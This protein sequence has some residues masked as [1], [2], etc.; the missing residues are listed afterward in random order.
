MWC[1]VFSV[2]LLSWCSGPAAAEETVLSVRRAETKARP[3][4]VHRYTAPAAKRPANLYNNHIANLGKE[5]SF[6]QRESRSRS[7]Y[8]AY[9]PS[10]VLT[11]EDSGASHV[12][13]SSPHRQPTH[14]AVRSAGLS[15]KEFKLLDQVSAHIPD[16]LVSG[17]VREIAAR[18]RGNAQLEK[19]EYEFLVGLAEKIPDANLSYNLFQIAEKRRKNSY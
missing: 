16:V 4:Q 8:R 6:K 1:V 5:H 3:R 17:K 9:T 11:S 13:T 12:L 15:E 7:D 19:E 18:Q 10:Q 14:L 2:L